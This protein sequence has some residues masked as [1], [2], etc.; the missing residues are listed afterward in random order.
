VI[1]GLPSAGNAPVATVVT[2]MVSTF[3][4]LRFGLLIGIGRGVPVETDEGTI[5]LSHVVVSKPTGQHSGA[6]QYNDGKAEAGEF[7][8]TGVLALPPHVLLNAAQRLSV[9][10]ALA[11]TDPLANNTQRID[12]SR[13]KLRRYRNPGVESDHLY[14]P[15]Y[16]H[17]N[18]K[19]SCQK[20]GCDPNRRVRRDTQDSLGLRRMRR[21]GRLD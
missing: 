3:P 11:P 20:C 18:R 13:P 16:V 10:R 5:R 7:R 2:R 9:V 4:K 1:A 8:R 19:A 14:E 12:T 17:V 6:V 21:I 15:D